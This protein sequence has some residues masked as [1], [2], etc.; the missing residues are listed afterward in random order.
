MKR[1]IFTIALLGLFNSLQAGALDCLV[2]V[3][4]SV[5]MYKIVIKNIPHKECWEEETIT[6]RHA[7]HSFSKIPTHERVVST[8]CISTKCRTAY[9]RVEEYVLVGYRNYAKY[10]C[11]TITKVSS[12]PL[13]QISTT[14]SY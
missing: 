12:C 9:E 14:V 13:T 10:G 3:Y 5:P 4:K 8:R 11:N 2:P 7:N 1:V 6:P